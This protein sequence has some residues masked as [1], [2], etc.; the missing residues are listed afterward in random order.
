VCA[1]SPTAPFRFA[2]RAQRTFRRL[3]CI[4]PVLKMAVVQQYQT[5]E[6]EPLDTNQ[7]SIRLI[8]VEPNLSP[9]GLVQCTLRHTTIDTRYNCLSYVWGPPDQSDSLLINGRHMD[10]SRNLHDFLTAVRIFEYPGL[11]H[12][13]R[14]H[15][16]DHLWIDAICIDQASI[17]E[18]NHQVGQMGKIYSNAGKVIMWLGCSKRSRWSLSTGIR[19]HLDFIRGNEYWTRAWVAQEVL[20]AKSPHLMV[21]DC[22][23]PFPSFFA[24]YMSDHLRNVKTE[25]VWKG[26]QRKITG[27]PQNLSVYKTRGVLW[28]Y[29][30]AKS[31]TEKRY[32]ITDLLFDLHEVKC[33]LPH[34]RVFSLLQLASDGALV[35]VDY[36]MPL[37][38][39]MHHVIKTKKPTQCL[40]M[41]AR[42]CWLLGVENERIDESVP[43][44][45]AQWKEGNQ[46]CRCSYLKRVHLKQAEW[47]AAMSNVRSR[48]Q[49]QERFVLVPV[50][51][52][53]GILVS[54]G[55]RISDMC[56]GSRNGKPEF[57]VRL[58]H[59]LVHNWT[60]VTQDTLS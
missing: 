29:R 6:H 25:T 2:K 33:T 35:P 58:G 14:A 44:V 45:Y 20:L 55:L 52:L 40:C 42:L 46:E 15:P 21:A 1:H 49:V 48:D 53:L 27:Q 24:D 13:S 3:R 43:T 41:I 54:P 9:E 60:S 17:A 23:V 32:S 28:A 5:F 51:L 31:I 34:D 18:K 57:P 30:R 10:I 36:S 22:L 7:P 50:Q 59:G 56:Q 8:S 38:G 47:D 4:L 11:G 39:L 26:T 19:A 16:R 37:A 12:R